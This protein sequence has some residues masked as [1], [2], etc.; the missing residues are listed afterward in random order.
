MNIKPRTEYKKNGM[1]RAWVCSACGAPYCDPMFLSNK[2][3]AGKKI[4][5]RL[6]QGLC[7]GCGKKECKCKNKGRK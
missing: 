2:T 7:I 1:K 4:N 3:P 5:K 6:Q